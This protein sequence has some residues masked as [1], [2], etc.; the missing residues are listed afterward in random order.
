[1][2]KLEDSSKDVDYEGHHGTVIRRLFHSEFFGDYEYART[3]ELMEWQEGY[4]ELRFRYYLRP[5]GG[6]DDAWIAVPSY[7]NMLPDTLVEL[8]RQA[9]N[10]SQFRDVL[11]DI[12][13]S[14]TGSGGLVNEA[15]LRAFKLEM[16]WKKRNQ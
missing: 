11:K 9:K 5:K 3:L 6:S 14:D 12:S 7:V 4:K 2:V 1:M 10:D 15:Q 8:L 13:V 16:D